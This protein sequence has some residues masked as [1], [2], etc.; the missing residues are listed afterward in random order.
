VRERAAA[1]GGEDP[2]A[3]AQPAAAETRHELEE[4]AAQDEA[5]PVSPKTDEWKP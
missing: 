3:D 4:E 1:V 5:E 2:S